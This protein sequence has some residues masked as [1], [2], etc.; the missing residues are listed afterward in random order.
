MHNKLPFCSHSGNRD[1][2]MCDENCKCH[3]LSDTNFN[4]SDCPFYKSKYSCMVLNNRSK[5]HGITN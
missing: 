5:K 3:L 2:F 4:T 1:C